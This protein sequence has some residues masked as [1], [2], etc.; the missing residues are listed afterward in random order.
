MCDHFSFAVARLFVCGHYI[1]DAN[2]PSTKCYSNYFVRGSTILLFFSKQNQKSLFILNILNFC[3]LRFCICFFVVYLITRS[4]QRS[5]SAGLSQVHI[6]GHIPPGLCLSSWSWNYYHIVNR[7]VTFLCTHC[8]GRTQEFTFI[9]CNPWLNK[10][11][12]VTAA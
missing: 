9:C 5:V 10:H 4:N 8:M 11:N 7:S 1:L 2:D 3:C 6:I 12:C